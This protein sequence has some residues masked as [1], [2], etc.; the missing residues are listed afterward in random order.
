[1]QKKTVESVTP[2]LREIYHKALKLANESERMEALKNLLQQEPGFIEARAKLRDLERKKVMRDSGLARFFAR[3]S[4]PTGK[5]KGLVKKNPV[6]AMNLCEDALLKTLDNVPILLLLSEAADNAG[7]PFI[8]AEA[9]ERAS[10]VRPFDH[11]FV[12]KIATYL[13]KSGRSAE[14]LKRLHVLATNN[15]NDKEIQNVYRQA[16]NFDAKQRDQAKNVGMA[17]IEEGGGSNAM[18]SRAAAI[19][20]LLEN[21]IHDA[22][23]AKLVA[24][25]LLKLLA[26]GDSMDVR[27]KLASAY[28]IMGDFDKA[29][30]EL[31]KVIAATAAYDPMLD[32]RLEEAEVGKIDKEIA[33]I[34]RRPPKELADPAGRIAELTEMRKQLQLDHALSRIEHY[35]NDVGLIYDLGKLRLERGE[36][37]LAIEQFMISRQSARNEVISHIGLAECYEKQENYPAAIEELETVLSIIPRLDKDRL[38][39]A[40]SLARIMEKIGDFAKA[41]AYYKELYELEPRFR[42]VKAKIDMLESG[43]AEATPPEAPQ[44]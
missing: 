2:E 20:Q 7:A 13:Q 33:Q 41:L 29:V 21:T 9:M 40:Y 4:N 17:Q 26:T 15:P 5:I 6:Q 1:M 12:L 3:L 32:K 19:L 42:D 39:T 14:A 18:G 31:N 23:Q 36:Y 28:V 38:T 27:R 34:K 35:P 22:A 37:E 16:I 43:N 10:E 24:N 11:S 30:A 25:E 8:S 44:Q